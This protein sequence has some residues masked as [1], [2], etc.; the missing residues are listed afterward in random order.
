VEFLQSHWLALLLLAVGLV[1]AALVLLLRQQKRA[2]PLSLIL[3]SFFFLLLGIGGLELFPSLLRAAGLEVN[4]EI[5]AAW[6]AGVTL[7][8]LAIMAVVVITTGHWF[9]PLGYS[10][11][12]LLLLGIGGLIAEPGS[13]LL[14]DF[15]RLSVSLEPGNPWWLGLL[16][17]IPLIFWFSFRSLAGLGPVRRWVAIGLRCLLILLLT[18]AL[19]DTHVR[20]PDDNL[21]VLFLWDRSLSIPRDFKADI[22]RREVRIKRFI[23]EAVEKRGPGREG[24][25]VGVLVFG[26]Q[27]RVELPP[28]N[29]PQL[30][31]NKI[32]SIVDDTAT[33]IAA[34]IKLALASFPEGTGKRI[35]LISDGNQNRGDAEEQAR[36]AK[37]NGV[38]ID[39]VPIAAGRRNPNEVLVERVEAP[40]ITEKDTRLPIRVVLRSYNPDTVV[41]TLRLN[42]IS[43]E[44][45][46]VGEGKAVPA[47]EARPVL[48]STV[49]LR[50]GLNPFFF[51]EP[52]SK[53]DDS[54]TYEAVFEP[55]HVVRDGGGRERLVGDRVENNRASTSVLA[56]GQRAVL[57][58][59][60]NIGDHKLL[61]D[62]LEKTKASLKVVSVDAARLP[63][64]STQ[65]AII[66][67][68]F[69]S[70]VLAN[71]PAE[72]L[73]EEQQKVIRSNTHDQGSGL[74]MIGGPQSFGAGGWQN[75]EV[76]KALPVTSDLK[77]MKVDAKSGLVLM[78]HASEMAEGNAWQKKIA[79]LAIEKLSPFDMVGML[80]YAWDGKGA[81]HTWHIPFQQIGQT[82][83]RLLGLVDSMNP[84]DM[85]D[86][87]PALQKA[88]DALTNPAHGLGT[89]HIIFISD[90]DH[91]DASRA[92]LAKIKAAK[93]TCTTVCITTH[94]QAEVKKMG[95]VAR[96]TGGRAYHIKSPEELPAIYIRET[97]LVSQSFVHEKTFQPILTT[98]GGPTEGLTDLEVLHGFVRTSRRSS[99][100]VEVAIETPKIGDSKFPILAYWHYGLGKSVAFTS[101]ARTTAKGQTF[102][103]RD[104]A[105]SPIYG[106]FWEQTVDWSLR[107]VDTGKHLNL[108]TEHRDG[109][110]RVIV[111]ARDGKK[112]P[113]TEFEEMKIGI[114][115]PSMKARDKSRGQ[116]EFE[117]KNSGVY[118]AEFNAE[119]TGSYFI[120]VQAKWK[121]EEGKVVTESVRAGVTL[122]YSPEFAEM[123]SNI[124]LLDRL[125]EIT[126][127]KT[128]PEE[129]AALSL[130]ARSGDIFRALPRSAHSLQSIW[131]WLV[132][133]AGICLFFDVAVRRITVDPRKL[134][135]VAQETWERLRGRAPAEK[136]PEFLERLKSRKAQVGE[137]FDRGKAARRF[138]GEEVAAAAPRGAHELPSAPAR[139]LGR[140]EAPARS[141]PE[142]KKEAGDFASRLLRAK[143][144]AMEERDKDKG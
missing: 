118:E 5:L 78:M 97:R 92:L 138:D 53:T 19:A 95:Y 32:V 125:R 44:M 68:K 120:N 140:P 67:S 137:A 110:V 126:G 17:L 52:G 61:A 93:I 14:S 37:Q 115:S 42:K 101:D 107:A 122:P 108:M 117:Q 81:G 40:S 129:E 130:V 31:F 100:L 131:P 74:V 111:E 25:R 91:W 87:D 26:R 23:N 73:T 90:G 1:L 119:E 139:P 2:W 135:S 8:A 82:R 134:A 43:L 49:R 18:L 33:D 70:V 60:P 7:A 114:T 62:R 63:Q 98:R 142:K 72:A 16:L 34:A 123:E 69:D 6:I 109:K 59:E 28:G 39:V 99:P 77:S 83:G 55:S 50:Y 36:L 29:V 84:G 56:R 105:N 24:D 21:T 85:P 47:F 65:L 10:V 57:L 15:G 104:W 12:A 4:S 94:G 127:G 103:D 116:I 71:L 89:K 22:D 3:W 66:L 54:F 41:G 128:I 76:E 124:A 9:A 38:Q 58:I 102:W 88:Y 144:R 48:E 11:G 112:R 13:R 132:V 46:K 20:K 64:D 79:K 143:R 35:V 51:Q 141:E 133:L 27:P 96:M 45:R 80:Y 136:I 86:V 75:T 106:K 121:D 113:I 30:R